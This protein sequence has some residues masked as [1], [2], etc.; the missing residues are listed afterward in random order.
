MGYKKLMLLGGEYHGTYVDIPDWLYTFSKYT[1][2]EYNIGT[3][4]IVEYKRINSPILG[5]ILVYYDTK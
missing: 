1:I 2:K 3:Y 5:D 4:G